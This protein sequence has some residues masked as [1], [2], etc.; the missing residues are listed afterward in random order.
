MSQLCG[1]LHKITLAIDGDTRSI[2][3]NSIPF[4]SHS[5]SYRALFSL[6]VYH[7]VLFLTP[8]SGLVREL[9]VNT[10]HCKR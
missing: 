8:K 4:P 7:T 10:K 1:V 5:A 9:Y 6:T 3:S 2:P